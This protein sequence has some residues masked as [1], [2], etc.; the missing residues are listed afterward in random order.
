MDRLVFL[1]F[2]IIGADDGVRTH[3][4]LVGNEKLYH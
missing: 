1:C 2:R 4:L 3:D